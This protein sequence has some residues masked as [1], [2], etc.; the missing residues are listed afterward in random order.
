MTTHS[1]DE[2]LI[3]SGSNA[4]AELR[5]FSITESADTREDTA[6]GETARTYKAGKTNWTAS[7]EAWWDETDTNGQETFIIGAEVTFGGYPEGDASGDTYLSGT[8]L[9]TERTINSDQEGIVEASFSLQ[10]SGALNR[11]TVV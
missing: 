9:I 1:G 2:G 7:V 6:M 10:G 5:S 3:K 11:S 8:A 4:L